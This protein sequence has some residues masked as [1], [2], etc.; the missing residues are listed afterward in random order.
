MYLLNHRCGDHLIGNA[1]DMAISTAASDA[2]SDE[3][4][5]PSKVSVVWSLE[6]EEE[7]KEGRKICLTHSKVFTLRGCPSL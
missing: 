2:R 3:E 4:E 5:G 1:T 6:E 7:E